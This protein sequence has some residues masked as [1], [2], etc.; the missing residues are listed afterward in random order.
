MET[1]GPGAGRLAVGQR[2]V[3]VPSASW[4]ALGAQANPTQLNALPR[5]AVD[6][7]ILGLEV[8]GEP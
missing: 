5:L 7:C 4:S 6:A 2:V 8:V 3:P 1:C